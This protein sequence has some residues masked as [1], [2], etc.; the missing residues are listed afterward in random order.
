MGWRYRKSIK[1]LP[2]VRV[3][4][5]L[6]SMSL[7]AGIP[8]FRTTVNSTGRVTKTFSIPGTGLS[9]VT[10]TSGSK[11]KK[12]LDVSGALSGNTGPASYNTRFR[13]SIEQSKEE[14]VRKHNEEIKAKALEFIQNIYGNSDKKIDWRKMLLSD[15]PF[16]DY[17]MDE[18]EF[19]HARAENVLNGDIDTYFEL[20]SMLNPF[21]DLLEYGSEFELGTEDPR[22]MAVHFKVNSNHVIK[23]AKKLSKEEYNYILQDYVCGASIRVARDLFAL[24]PLRHII[25]TAIDQRKNILSV[26]FQLDTF[27]TLNF[28]A[29]DASDTIRRFKHRME[30]SSVAGFSKVEELEG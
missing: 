1:L 11:R 23:E 29:L 28:T 14:L 16:D 18:W 30:F 22:M 26:D 27:Q 17:S 4:F 2:G 3:N 7:S 10:S 8:G 19:Y 9:Y 12:N 21:N 13:S 6:R 5:G 15:V 25:V 24:L 20:V